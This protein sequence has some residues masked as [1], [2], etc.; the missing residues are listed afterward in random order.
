MQHVYEIDALDLAD[1]L[2]KAVHNLLRSN[3][4]GSR[5]ECIRGEYSG[6]GAGVNEEAGHTAVGSTA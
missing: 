2:L 3:G 5:R 6:G 4:E 1:T